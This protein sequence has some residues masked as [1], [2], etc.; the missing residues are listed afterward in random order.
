MESGKKK[1]MRLPGWFRKRESLSPGQ[2]AWMK[3]RKNPLSLSGLILIILSI[4]IAL[5]GYLITPDATPFANEQILEIAT[6]KPGF[7]LQVLKVRKNEISPETGF[8]KKLFH[9]EPSHFIIVPIQS[10]KF[11]EEEIH[12][13]E[14]AEYAGTEFTRSFHIAD[15]VYPLSYGQAFESETNGNIK[16]FPADGREIISNTDK[17]KEDILANHITSRTYLLGTDRYGRD[18]LSRIIIGARVSLSVGFIAVII[19]V[20]IGTL[21]GLLAGYFGGMVDNII[22]WLINVIWS[23]PTLLMVIA[24]TLVLGKGFWQVFIAVGLTMWVEVARVVRGQ[25]MGIRESE[26]IEAARALGYTNK[27]ILWKHV[28]PNALDPVIIIS[29]ANFSSA[30]LIEAGLSFLG[31]GVQP[32][33]PS[34]GSMIRDHYGFIIVDLGYLAIIPGIAI[35]LMVLSFTLVGNGLRDAYDPKNIT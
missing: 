14:F 25:V 26:Y 35:M 22:L 20:L 13:S 15:V 2:I 18:M 8:F 11:T 9:G 12:V 32:P 6:Q 24:I 3:F 7:K 5:S 30:I 31:M 27:R 16:I 4:L 28:L 33:V 17:L 1:T 21:L 19:S 23:V 34:W 10:W 29:A